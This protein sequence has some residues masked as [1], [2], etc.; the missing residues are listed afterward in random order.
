MEKVDYLRFLAAHADSTIAEAAKGLDATEVA[1][2]SAF[3]RAVRQKLAQSSGLPPRYRLTAEGEARLRVLS[4][5]SSE[6]N[7]SHAADVAQRVARLEGKI[8]ALAERVSASEGA[9]EEIAADLETLFGAVDRLLAS[10]GQS[11]AKPQSRHAE[12]ISARTEQL[13]ARFEKLTGHGAAPSKPAKA[14]QLYHALVRLN[15]TPWFERGGIRDET[16]ALE[17]QLDPENVEAIK[18]LC[19][20]ERERVPWFR[21]DEEMAKRAERI[22][23]L[24]EKLGL[25]VAIDSGSDKAR[26][27]LDEN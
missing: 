26:Q 1:V 6:S 12:S 23:S 22:R 18:G 16:L 4:N 17:S 2:Q 3:K 7:P 11:D 19:E 24:R 5:Q 20:L 14:Q 8:G 10:E 13:L 25:T 15:D 21:R 27:E 9:E